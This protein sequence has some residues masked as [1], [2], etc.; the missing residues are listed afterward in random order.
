MSPKSLK[1]GRA[2][3]NLYERGFAGIIILLIVLAGI[4][5]LGYLVLRNKTIPIMPNS[6]PTPTNTTDPTANWKTYAVKDEKVSFKYPETWQLL[7]DEGGSYIVASSDKKTTLRTTGGYK[8]STPDKDLHRYLEKQTSYGGQDLKYLS[9][10]S[11]EIDGMKGWYARI[12][13]G[14]LNQEDTIFFIENKNFSDRYTGLWLVNSSAS[15]QTIFDQI[16]STFKFLRPGG[17][18]CQLSGKTYQNGEIVSSDKCN[19]CACDNGQ[20]AC[21]TMACE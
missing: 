13:I 14:A 2:T 11:F 21:T 9:E 6:S 17:G 5:G 19:S 18:S 15:Y 4:S 12:E 8:S 10:K 20:I 3:I 1:S 7:E 16:L